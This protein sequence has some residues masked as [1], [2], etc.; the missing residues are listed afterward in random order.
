MHMLIYALVEASHRDEALAASKSAFD[1]LT[2]AGPDCAPVFD[3][4][5][6]FDQ[7]GT[8]VAGTAR[9]GEL[10]VAASI[11]SEEGQHLLDR[12]WQATEQEF[13][14]N[15]ERVKQ[16]L[17]EYSDEAIM[18][19]KDLIRHACHQL[20]AYEGSS[21][22]LYDEFGGGIRHRDRLDMILDGSDDLWIVPADVHF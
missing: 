5:V 18:C 1:R 4:Y 13:Q 22:F 17:E 11:N 2:G 14:R 16:G 19:D 21:V 9:W 7:D 12:G 6:T 8:S 10:P 3:Y 20:G 15:L